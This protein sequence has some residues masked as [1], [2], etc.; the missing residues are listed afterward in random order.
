MQTSISKFFRKKPAGG[1]TN[2]SGSG[3]CTEN[4][5]S[6]T[7]KK[8]VTSVNDSIDL[9]GGDEDDASEQTVAVTAPAKKARTDSPKTTVDSSSSDSFAVKTAISTAMSSTSHKHTSH[10]QQAIDRAFPAQSSSNVCS[11]SPTPTAGECTGKP[12]YTPLEKQVVDIRAN[13]P[14]CLLMVQCGYKFRFFGD[15]ASTAAKVLNIYC[16]P[17]HN[18]MVA[19]IPTFRILVHL[20][21][22]VAAGFK[23]PKIILL[24]SGY[25]VLT[26]LAILQVA[27]VRQSESAAIHKASKASGATFQRHVAGVYTASS[28]ITEADDPAYCDLL[29]SGVATSE[30]GQDDEM[31]EEDEEDQVD[32]VRDATP[33][34]DHADDDLMVVIH[35]VRSAH[36]DDKEISIALTGVSI[37]ANCFR[38]EWCT[39]S[40]IDG[41]AQQLADILDVLR[42]SELLILGSVDATINGVITERVAGA[43]A[44]GGDSVLPTSTNQYVNRLARLQCSD[45]LASYTHNNIACGFMDLLAIC[46]V[47]ANVAGKDGARGI[48]RSSTGKESKE[49]A[50]CA[51]KPKNFLEA[52]NEIDTDWTTTVNRRFI[53]ALVALFQYMF[54]LNTYTVFH[55]ATV[56]IE[57][58][59]EQR[60]ASAAGTNDTDNEK[61]N[62]GSECTVGSLQKSRFKL[63]PIT[64]KDL[65]VFSSSTCTSGSKLDENIATLT[66]MSLLSLLSQTASPAGSR[67]VREWLMTPLASITDITCRQRA[68]QWVR[69]WSGDSAGKDQA[70][71]SSTD[72]AAKLLVTRGRTLIAQSKEIEP[73]LTAL[74]HRRLQP[75]KTLQLLRFSIS[76]QEMGK[77]CK[78]LCENGAE[79]PRDISLCVQSLQKSCDSGELAEKMIVSIDAEAVSAAEGKDISASAALSDAEISSDVALKQL[80][81]QRQSLEGQLQLELVRIRRLLNKP[82]LAWRTLRTG[83]MSSVD[84]LIEISVGDA[85]RVERIADKE[86]WKC[87]SSTKAFLRFHTPST[88]TLLGSLTLCNDEI[89][90]GAARMWSSLLV[91]IDRALHSPLRRVFS[92]LGQLD[93]FLGFAKISTWPGYVWPIYDE[94]HECCSKFTL[95]NARHPLIDLQLNASG[96][97]FSVF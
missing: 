79:L 35:E 11:G 2:N 81:V 95:E 8:R 43:I 50:P 96:K 34:A 7:A 60:Q 77:I 72:T 51:G 37:S 29:S 45:V 6:S 71:D 88:Q 3:D 97:F 75:R 21:R 87:V 27:V 58:E 36:F 40:S 91:K 82:D 22:L 31:R 24:R 10:L 39:D 18:F 65:D 41:C 54:E 76:L 93:A 32:D 80:F 69:R 48:S 26:V 30:A 25:F 33:L 13:Y 84:Y 64:A 42:P 94:S 78:K 92:I 85:P 86:N 62:R 4:D 90:R 55:D 67:C 19:S 61:D 53:P 9:T 52:A 59:S 5:H 20:R 46:S 56:S 44:E 57:Q 89:E 47:T 17:D 14:D 66:S 16:H 68:V 28:V 70:A 74:H 73:L 1:A 63:H 49:T 23:V 12:N 83:A 38:F 15:D